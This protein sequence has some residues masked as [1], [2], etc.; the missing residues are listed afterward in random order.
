MATINISE[1]NPAGSNLL[2]DSE[3]YLTELSTAE[4]GILGGMTPNLSPMIVNA[5]SPLLMT[6]PDIPPVSADTHIA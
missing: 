2:T 6:S 4:M 1:L 3:T 5:I